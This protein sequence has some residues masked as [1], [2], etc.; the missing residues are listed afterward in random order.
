MAQKVHKLEKE[1]LR[2]REREKLSPK[3]NTRVKKD[4][5]FQNYDNLL[6]FC[7]YY[8]QIAL[9]QELNPKSI[10]EIGIGNKMYYNYLKNFGYNITSCDLD[11]QLD[12]DYVADIRNLPFEKNRFEVVSAFEVLEHLPFS[13]VPKALMELKRVTSKYCILSIPYRSATFEI[14]LRFPFIGKILKKPF[15]NL[16]FRFPFKTK[17]LPCIPSED[18][19]IHYWE[20]GT[21]S[22]PLSRIRNLINSCGFI[23]EKEVRPVLDVS[24]YFLVLYKKERE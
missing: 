1:N 18:G 3:F 5:Y 17:D 16:F 9:T 14:T 10:L 12:P 7:Y 6:K 11:K 24:S 4:V 19:Q 23:I 21:K 2:E 8:C 15:L 22:Y 13:E 20:I